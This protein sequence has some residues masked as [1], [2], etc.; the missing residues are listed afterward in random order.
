MWLCPIE[1]ESDFDN[2]HVCLI[3]Q[4]NNNNCPKGWDYNAKID[5]TREKICC[6]N[7]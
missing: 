4:N 3:D 7:T 2:K 5:G 6:R 1:K